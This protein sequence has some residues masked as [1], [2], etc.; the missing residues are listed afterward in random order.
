MQMVALD[1]GIQS[2]IEA[3]CDDPE[4]LTETLAVV[5]ESHDRA[6]WI[7]VESPAELLMIPENLSSEVVGPT[8]FEEFMRP[9]QTEWA[10]KRRIGDKAYLLRTPVFLA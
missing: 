5:K 1:A 10:A 8:L 7:A 3:Q 9:Y 4:L 6:A 2:L